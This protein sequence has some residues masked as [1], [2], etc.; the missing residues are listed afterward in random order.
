MK[1]HKVRPSREGERLSPEDQLA[2]KLASMAAD[3]APSDPAAAEMAKLRII[4]DW[5]VGLAALNRPAVIAARGTAL[6]HPRPGGATLLGLGANLRFDCGWAG[7]ANAVAFREL[8]FNDSFFASDSGHP[9]D[10]IGPIAAV[11]QQAGCDG[12]A[13]LRAI[14]TAYE[15]QVNLIKGIALNR[16]R[17]DHVAHL[18][19][20]IAGGIGAMLGLAVPVLHQA[21]SLA[22]HL[23]I[24]TR[25]TRKGQISSYKAAA[26]GHIGQIAML[27][28][29]R[30]MRGETSPA[31]VYEG[32]YGIF[33][34]L[35]G[36]PEAAVHVPLPEPGEPK[37]AI[38]ETYPKAHAA[39]YHGQAFIDLAIRMR[40]RI[41]DFDQIQEIVLHTKA[42]THLVMGSGAG[43]PEKSDPQASRE[44]LDHSVMFIFAVALQDGAWHHEASYTP[45]RVS[46]PDTVRLWRKIRT[47]EDPDWTR[48]FQEPD[49][50]DK[51]HGGRAVVTLRDGSII[52]DELAVANAHP[53]GSRPFGRDDYHAKFRRLA[54]GLVAPDGITVFLDAVDGLGEAPPQG[55]GALAIEVDPD[56]LTY[57]TSGLFAIA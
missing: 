45:A 14:V 54:G 55:L 8:D 25:Q 48:R 23:S 34:I 50:L 44:T 27:A 12:P 52:E 26:P 32:D 13:L 20:A 43:D 15:I 29:D 11:A 7:Y 3:A 33:A 24:S 40:D 10:A 30:A 17:I 19:P 28:V 18:G 42:L 22:A 1:L 35:L 38:L 46:R 47:V 2:W 31:P 6:A 21:I 5:A 36:G 56:K 37:R 16:Y 9:G 41:A 57:G 53:R 4:D 51:A 49:P 39:G